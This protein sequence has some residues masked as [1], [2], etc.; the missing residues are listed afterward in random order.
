MIWLKSAVMAFNQRASAQLINGHDHEG[1]LVAI[2]DIQPGEEL[3]W[4]YNSAQPY[5]HAD[6]GDSDGDRDWV[7]WEEGSRRLND[8]KAQHATARQQSKC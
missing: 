3:L 8:A 5:R 1:F 4:Y 7:N 2:K 6:T